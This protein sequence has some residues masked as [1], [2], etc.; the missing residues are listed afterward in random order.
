[1]GP[2][3]QEMN[4]RQQILAEAY[5][6]SSRYI[7]ARTDALGNRLEVVEQ[8]MVRLEGNQQQMMLLLVQMQ[9][10][11]REMQQQMIQMQQENRDG[12]AFQQMMF[13][14]LKAFAID[15]QKQIAHSSAALPEQINQMAVRFDRLERRDAA[16]DAA[17]G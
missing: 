1:M 3:P 10:Q 11:Q 17:Q 16:E 14:T 4:E 8:H 7:D 12:R 6:R 9:Q 15:I 2:Q 5:S 13:D